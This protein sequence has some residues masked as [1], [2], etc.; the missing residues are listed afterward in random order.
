MVRTLP[1]LRSLDSV[2]HVLDRYD[3]W[4]R[5]QDGPFQ[6]S[7]EIRVRVTAGM[8]DRQRLTASLKGSVIGEGSPTRGWRTRRS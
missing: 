3:L 1:Q 7:V 6:L 5:A 4:D 2:R 8:R